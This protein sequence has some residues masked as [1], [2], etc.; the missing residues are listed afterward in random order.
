MHLLLYGRTHFRQTFCLLGQNYSKSSWNWLQYQHE[1][2]K[3]TAVRARYRCCHSRATN[4]TWQ[5]FEP[6]SSED[7]RS[8]HRLRVDV[9]GLVVATSGV[10]PPVKYGGALSELW[11]RIAAQVSRC[12]V[13]TP[14]LKCH[15]FIISSLVG[16]AEIYQRKVLK[17]AAMERL[18]SINRRETWWR[19]K[20]KRRLKMIL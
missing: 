9:A 7:L 15:D 3:L 1:A 2:L 14:A 11:R 4:L 18:W 16:R 13:T 19:Q 17:S 6:G 8:L 20:D 10:W 5:H 12:N